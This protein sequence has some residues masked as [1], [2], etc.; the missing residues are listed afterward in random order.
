MKI[1]VD[2]RLLSRPITG[3][4][5]YTLEM[6]RAL[7]HIKEI[8]L[9]LYAP[10]PISP[11]F[12][13][14]LEPSTVRSAHFNNRFLRQ[15]WSEVCLPFWARQD[16][17]DVFWGPT[18]RIP[19]WLPSRTARVL[20]IHDLVWK[21]A[22]ETM[23]PFSKT[24]EQYQMPLA[25]KKADHIVVDSKAIANSLLEEF[26]LC[27]NKITIISLGSNHLS[28]K[29]DLQILK[30][31]NIIKPYCLFVGTL[32]PRKNLANLLMAYS[33]LPESSK[34]KIM[35]LIAGD[36]GWGDVNLESLIKNLN[37]SSYV[38]LLGFVDEPTL[39]TLYAYARFLVLPSLY[40]GFGLPLVEAMTYSLPVLTSNNSAMIEIAGNAGVLV[41][42][43][44]K[45]SIKQG[46]IQL[47]NDDK[48]YNVLSQNAKENVRR[49]N[50]QFSANQLL[51][52]F[53]EAIL[54]RKSVT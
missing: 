29:V 34:S 36:T 6:C 37:L 14:S 44:D 43:L 8:S 35:L 53:K 48:L 51:T 17:V 41:D 20:T 13:S 30:N 18:H 24:L 21:F 28:N 54:H 47:I 10:S 3:I 49:F 38:K 32:E 7:S 12:I 22:G 46:L 9:Y 1:G 26:P 27:K 16:R 31:M 50:W 39:A 33:K 11:E 15:I 23:R 25:I 19:N 5:R 45:E 4:G 52:V 42:P 40:E 2:A